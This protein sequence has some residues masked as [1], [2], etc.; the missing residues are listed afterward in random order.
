LYGSFGSIDQGGAYDDQLDEQRLAFFEEEA[1]RYYSNILATF[2]SSVG[3]AIEKLEALK[4]RIIAPAHGIVWREHPERIVELYRRHVGYS[5]GEA[6][7]EIT[8]I[9]GSMYGMTER[10]VEAVLEGIRSEG[11]LVREFRVP[12][13]HVSHILAAAWRSCG[14]VLA[15][16]TYEYKMFPPMAT[17]LD[18]LGRKKVTGKRAFRFGSYGWSGGAQKE[19]EEI[20]ERLRMKW[21]FVEPY[22]FA[23]APAEED[24]EALRLRARAFAAEVKSNCGNTNGSRQAADLVGAQASGS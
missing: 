3:R 16:P 7:P 17:V 8:L 5:R 12:Q 2:S 24:L 1:S 20:M 14:I 19:L 18:E 9:W 6:E 23:G 21:S 13:N 11:V 10:A 15:A 4:P 22:E